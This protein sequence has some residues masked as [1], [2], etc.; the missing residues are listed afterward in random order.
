MAVATVTKREVSRGVGTVDIETGVFDSTA[1]SGDVEIQ[2]KLGRLIWIRLWSME[3]ASN[4][5]LI[6]Y[7]S[8]TA[9]NAQD[10]AGWFHIPASA[11]AA[12]E[13]YGYEARAL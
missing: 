3:G 2:T 8:K 13:D 11:L 10:D 12:S 9:S 6:Y 1:S 7:N 4:N 5:A